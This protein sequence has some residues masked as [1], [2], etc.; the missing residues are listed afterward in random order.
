MRA[1]RAA[2][3][4]VQLWLLGL[5]VLALPLSAW[6]AL[7]PRNTWLQLGPCLVLLLVAVPL[8]RRWPVSTASLRNI[9]LFLL[10]HS[11][12]ARWSYSF[13]PYDDWVR[14]LTGWSLDA[15]L[16]F[17]RNMF[18]RFVHLAFGLLAIRPAREIA[19]RSFG[20]SPRVALYIAPEF[21]LATSAFYEIFEWQLALFMAPA[22]A[23]AYN[24]QQGDM[25][26]P[27][28]DMALA[29][30]GATVATA[31]ELFRRR[32]AK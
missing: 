22:D 15:A 2:V 21:V 18:D 32:F 30:L 17:K 14:A 5:L 4:P 6:D 13:V 31:V 12:A 20:L 24:G 1:S 26:D 3:P 8:L 28:K 9:I 29:A 19:T 23:A 16:G 10:L 27:Q 7:Y 11:I 25:F